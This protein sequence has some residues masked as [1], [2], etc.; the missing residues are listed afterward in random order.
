MTQTGQDARYL[1]SEGD[2]PPPRPDYWSVGER[3]RAGD[4]LLHRHGGGAPGGAAERMALDTGDQETPYV[5][6]VPTSLL[7]RGRLKL[8]GDRLVEAD[9]RALGCPVAVAVQ[10]GLIR[11][12]PVLP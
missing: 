7:L 3:S 8:H 1:P 9:I 6:A 2:W 11:E 12:L 10:R 4:R 5:V